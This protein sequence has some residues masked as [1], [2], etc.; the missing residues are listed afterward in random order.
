MLIKAFRSMGIQRKIMLLLMGVGLLSFLALG[1]VSFAGLWHVQEDALHM[2]VTMGESVAE[3]SEEFALREAKERLLSIA[4]E[5]S[6]RAEEDIIEVLSDA[7]NLANMTEN[8]MMHRE[9]YRPRELTTPHEPLIPGLTPYIY[10]T[11]GAKEEIMSDPSL[12]YKVGIL[13]NI[14]D[15]L[16]LIARYYDRDTSCY[17]A[18][19]TGCLIWVDSVGA[20]NDKAEYLDVYLEGRYDSKTRPWYL[21]AKAAGKPIVTDVYVSV[22]GGSEITCA[23][24]YYEDGVFAGVAG[25]STPLKVLYQLVLNNNESE[26]SIQ[27]ALDEKGCVAISSRQEGTWAVGAGGEDGLRQYSA[28]ERPLTENT[29]KAIAAMMAGD[30]GTAIVED[31]DGKEYVLAYSPMPTIGWSYG[32]LIEREKVVA[33]ARESKAYV[34]ARAGDFAKTMRQMFLQN[35]L[36]MVALL[37]LIMLGIAAVSSK[38]AQIFVQPLLLL[39]AG[40][41]E[42]ATGNLDTRLCV[43]TG[44]E[45]EVLSDSVNDMTTE[46]KSYIEKAKERERIEGELEGARKIQAGMLPNIFPEFQNRKELDLYASMTPAKEVGGDFYDFYML[47]KQRL[48]VT[49]ADVSGKGIPASLFMVISKAILKKCAMTAFHEADEGAVD[50]GKVIQEANAELCENNEEDMFVTVFFGVLDLKSGDFA[51][52]N[53]GHNPPLICREGNYEYLR[54]EK[55]SMMLGIFDPVK[56][57]E[58][59]LTLAPGEMIFFYTDGVTEAMDHE[60]NL[61]GEEHLQMKLNQVETATASVE[62]ILVAIRADIDVHAD[63]AE[64]SDD[65]TMLGLRFL[66]QDSD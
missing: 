49:I 19:E 42:I 55:K 35:I 50:W 28:G 20:D 24:P 14:G 10:Y 11:R 62:E 12:R 39:T 32:I 21:K 40:V 18:S 26:D 6:S 5:K 9:R 23:A 59:H 34:M 43:K 37:A 22:E 66:G 36:T 47:D 52:V 51:Y 8:I 44:D 29:D 45:I 33:P 64:Q 25:V 30:T 27:F 63:G 3:Y 7:R 16:E 17:I 1:L 61:Y 46:L 65:I 57:L 60:G 4:R 41:K 56:Y 13:A 2:G 58:Y 31:A 53:G 15:N 54:M 38:A 48:V